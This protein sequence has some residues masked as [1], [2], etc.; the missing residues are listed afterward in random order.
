M[1]WG[2]QKGI[3]TKTI[4]QIEIKKNKQQQIMHGEQEIKAKQN[5]AKKR[6]T[7]KREIKKK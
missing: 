5:E 6:R 3:A 1:E 4:W 2:T 7:E